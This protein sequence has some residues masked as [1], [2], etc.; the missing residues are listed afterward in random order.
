MAVQDV[1]GQTDSTWPPL[2]SAL[3]QTQKQTTQHWLKPLKL[4][5]KPNSHF[6]NR[7]ERKSVLCWYSILVSSVYKRQTIRAKEGIPGL[8][9]ATLPH[10][11]HKALLFQ[12]CYH[13]VRP[14]GR[15]EA[16]WGLNHLPMA[17]PE[18]ISH[19]FC[20]RPL[21]MASSHGSLES[22]RIVP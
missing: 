7:T 14:E 11:C 8:A 19:F 5:A 9:L 3:P 18:C 16:G 1:R 20:I 17:W 22:M 4:C 2:H 21:T 12:C 6:L 15:T 10:L 13:V